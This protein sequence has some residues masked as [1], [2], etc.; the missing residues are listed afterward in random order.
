MGC[1]GRACGLPPSRPALGSGAAQRAAPGRGGAGGTPGLL[2]AVTLVGLVGSGV[3][4]GR[5][6]E[7]LFFTKKKKKN[8]KK[9]KKITQ[10]G[11]K[12]EDV[13]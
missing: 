8:R 6:R 5:G 3:G 10:N 9:K 13:E 1:R 4:R 11:T 12:S 2:K 7:K